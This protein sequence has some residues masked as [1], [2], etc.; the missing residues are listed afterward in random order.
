MT[1]RPE[2]ID[3]LRTLARVISDLGVRFVV[4]GATA[5]W[6]LAAATEG[7]RPTRDTDA[8]VQ[9][10]TSASFAQIRQRLV[11]AGFAYRPPR[12][13]ES[14]AGAI[15]D[16]IPF[17]PDVVRTGRVEWPTGDTM[18]AL[19]LE[20]AF[21]SAVRRRIAEG[22]EVEVASEV[23]YGLLKIIAY[24]ER[25]HE[26]GHDVA[27]LVIAFQRYEEESERQYALGAVTVDGGPVTY[28]QAGAYLMGIDIHR[29][30]R[31]ASREVVIRFLDTIGDAYATPIYHALHEMG[32]LHSGQRREEIYRFFR[33]FR[34]GILAAELPS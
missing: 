2:D 11:E 23:A 16:L 20:E 3:A 26:R 1:L 18:S 25:P 14:A 34:A 7:L 5:P 29:L 17:G 33:V 30:A 32:Q 31:P 27:D 21:S 28:E 12:R 24:D 19:G 22:F 15:L 6:I 9:T 10:S 8:V 4:V 13:F